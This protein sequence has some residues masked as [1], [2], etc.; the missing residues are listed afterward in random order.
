M[1]QPN[2]R[3][4]YVGN[5]AGH[6]LT[7]RLPI[8]R[9]L[10]QAGYEI[11]VAVPP[12]ADQLE[13]LMTDNGNAA[14]MIDKMGFHYHQI[15]LNRGGMNP[16]VELRSLVSLFRLY[17]R[18][19]PD[20]VFHATI[21]PII[22]GNIIARVVRI[23][24]AVNLI[25]G[26]GYIF[27]A[28]GVKGAVLRFFAKSAYG[29]AIKRPNAH[30]I[31]QNS[32]DYQ[33]FLTHHIVNAQNASIVKGSG[34][35][36]DRFTFAPDPPEPVVTVLSSRM[37]WDKGISEFVEAAT[38]IK[39][40]GVEG[41]FIL[42]GD[43]DNANP[44]AISR[45]QLQTWHDSGAVEWL[46]WRQDVPDILRQSHIVCLPT[47]YREGIPKALIEAAACGRPIVTTDAPGCREIV[48]DGENGILV[49]VRNVPA[50]VDALKTLMSD[51]GLRQRMGKRSREIVEIDFSEKKIGEQVT[52]IC[53]TL[54]EK[55][56]HPNQRSAKEEG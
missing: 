26:L 12:Q 23:P 9:A 36:M 53:E 25:S 1:T 4:L 33:I 52:T 27:L 35:D 16:L 44:N 43:S 31:F 38:Q 7:H 17:Q 46:G 10:Q 41:R 13:Q 40:A 45:Q 48:K 8:F 28:A 32:D 30:T 51:P 24:S 54:L 50:L 20:L 56:R 6:F 39:A 34:V 49:P 37:L 14:T 55:A 42:L 3:I 15:V 11:H 2:A 22:Y 19:K 21:K 5:H 47:A 29:I 18:L